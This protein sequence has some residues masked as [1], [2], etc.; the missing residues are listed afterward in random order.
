MAAVDDK[1]GRE[2]AELARQ[3]LLWLRT[4][5]LPGVPGLRGTPISHF[6]L[7]AGIYRRTYKKLTAPMWVGEPEEERRIQ[8]LRL[9]ATH[10]L[11]VTPP[12]ET[13]VSPSGDLIRCNRIVETGKVPL[14][15]PG[16]LVT[17][18][19]M[20]D[21][22]K[23]DEAT[24]Q[25]FIKFAFTTI[26]QR[27]DLVYDDAAAA[28]KANFQYP[29]IFDYE[30]PRRAYENNVNE[31]P[32]PAEIRPKP[33]SN[34][35]QEVLAAR[36]RAFRAH[37]HLHATYVSRGS[38]HYAGN[39]YRKWR[40]KRAL[41]PKQRQFRPTLLSDEYL[42]ECFAEFV[43]KQ[44][45]DYLM[46]V[47]PT[48]RIVYRL[49]WE[50]KPGATPGRL[51]VQP[52]FSI[53][54]PL[55]PPAPRLRR[56]GDKDDDPGDSGLQVPIPAVIFRAL[57]GKDESPGQIS[58]GKLKYT[59]GE[60]NRFVV[61]YKAYL[62]WYYDN[63]Q[64][65]FGTDKEWF[66]EFVK[67]F[68][69]DQTYPVHLTV[70][71]AV[72]I[73]RDEL[74]LNELRQ[75]ASKAAGSM[76]Q[77]LTEIIDWC[78]PDERNYVFIQGM[79]FGT[80]DNPRELIGISPN[81]EVYEWNPRTA[82]VT[83]TPIN[84]WLIDF[85]HSLVYAEV[86]RNTAGMLPFITLITWGGVIVATGGALG[87]GSTM[88]GLSRATVPELVKNA[89]GKFI[90]KEAV[91]KARLQLIAMLVDG[92]LSLMPSS[93][94]ILYQFLHG[95]FEGFGGGAVE[96]YLSEID[97]RLERQIDKIPA[98]AA[99]LATKGGYRAYVVYDKLSSA[100]VRLAAVV[101]ALK[102]VLTEQRAQIAAQQLRRLGH[103]AGVAFLIILFVVVYLDY[104]YRSNLGKNQKE[105]D[106]WVEK[107]KKTLVFM[108]RETGDEIASYARELQDELRSLR[109]SVSG[110]LAKSPE[111]RAAVRRQDERLSR[112]I[113]G[114]LKKGLDEVPA[115]A[116]FLQLLI[117]QMGVKNWDELK[118][119]GFGEL[120]ARG[121]DAL[122]K[123]ALAGDQAHKLGAALGELIG[124][125]MLERQI[126]PEGVRKKGGMI[127]GHPQ[128][129]AAKGA[130]AGGTWRALWQFAIYPFENLGN[131]PA[132]LKR[133]LEEQR[134]WYDNRF[135]TAK[136]R[137][138][139]YRDF[140]RDLI[141]DE[142]E[143]AR[144]LIRLAEDEGLKEHLDRLVLSAKDNMIPP[145][146]EALTKGDNPEWPTDAILFVLYTWLR[147]GLR[148]ILQGFNLINDAQP[149]GGAFKLS[150]LLDIIGLD[151]ALDDT[152][153]A[154]L[155]A[156]FTR[157]K[158]ANP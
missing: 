12:G 14:E 63:Q 118:S 133:G 106:R 109:K 66:D 103:H 44:G 15:K 102:T 52:Q 81:Y 32:V 4:N 84:K 72:R 62:R 68:F 9:H 6:Q 78:K 110:S 151:I 116:D 97:D 136:H 152:T 125:I 149:Y 17:V 157:I 53:G 115:V 98:I 24:L 18:A 23:A 47:L 108:V 90:A 92:L 7:Y 5:E 13:E 21:S 131:M 154:A 46:I 33:G 100:A 134:G 156:T 135:S 141:G 49:L 19:P 77:R 20:L 55:E 121:F 143:L 87:L 101:K 127:F 64:L 74:F 128:H 146:L 117:E 35:F 137:D 142:D 93:D 144:R 150:E 145:D 34:R 40:V 123:Q 27:V 155:R 99:N 105:I 120:M 30:T 54:A 67:V 8:G 70:Y 122:P 65:R 114:K 50:G 153:A 140:V 76:K 147:L 43:M 85:Q 61:D 129:Q 45:D 39:Y 126:V 138:T 130:L 91:R 10:V 42:K 95:L 96:H 31:L 73:D 158:T 59:A 124:T 2:F 132:T 86:Y 60:T 28:A 119:L 75:E 71:P 38:Q 22:V 36:E 88:V 112:A 29:F 25:T 56:K 51:T 113:G 26:L 1:R 82:L 83:A 11:L 80:E 111:A 89:A 104:V 41:D 94:H 37:V 148:E 79:R 69:G 107:Q 57:E 58:F 16:A 48:G 139:S 3:F